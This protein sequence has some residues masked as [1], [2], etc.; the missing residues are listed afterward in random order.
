MSVITPENI[1]AT[2]PTVTVIW[3]ESNHLYDG[4]VLSLS[5]ANDAFRELDT[6]IH[7]ARAK[8]G[9][10]GSWYDK[11]KF[12]LDFWFRGEKDDY[13]GRQDFGDHQG[14]GSLLDHI[15]SYHR[16]YAKD[17]HWKAHVLST[18]GEEAWEKDVAERTMILTEF[19]PYLRLH[20][21]LSKMEN[22]ARD[23][24]R[25]V[26]EHSASEMEYFDAVLAYVQAMRRKLNSG[27]YDL[28]PAPYLADFDP[29]L[30]R[31]KEQVIEEIRAEAATLNMTVEEYAASGYEAPK[32]G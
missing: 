17:K 22:A 31:Y 19:V 24:Q 20:I 5:R 13:S 3:S 27:E 25:Y 15:E 32:G 6:A 1:P 18:G 9:Y 30:E 10:E 11:T 8:P 28:P 16:Y 14:D 12:K 2:E 4:Q 26:L 29:E 23:A 21:V 7:T